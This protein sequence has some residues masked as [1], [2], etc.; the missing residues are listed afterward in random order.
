V[1]YNLAATACRLEDI[2]NMP[3]L[4]T[5]GWQNKVKQLVRVT[6]EQ[7]AESS[8]SQHHATLSLPSQTTAIAN[9]GSSML[10]PCRWWEVVVTP[11]ATALIDRELGAL[12]L[13]RSKDVTF[14]LSVPHTP[15][16][17]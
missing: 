13:G 10:I 9:K 2:S 6:L 4:K 1:A 7:Q 8:A 16:D 5:N 15:L 3:D 14:L 17:Q 12:S 11:L